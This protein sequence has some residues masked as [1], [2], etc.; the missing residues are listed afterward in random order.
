MIPP[1]LTYL[2]D[3][4][5][6]KDNLLGAAKGTGANWAKDLNLPVIDIHQKVFP[7]QHADMRHC[8]IADFTGLRHCG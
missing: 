3:N 8:R 5:I 2:A 7:H 6:S 4:I 1:G